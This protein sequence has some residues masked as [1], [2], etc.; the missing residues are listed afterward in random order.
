MK[1]LFFLCIV[2]Y[3]IL[4]AADNSDKRLVYWQM[5]ESS[6]RQEISGLNGSEIYPYVGDILSNCLKHSENL[7]KAIS[8][9]SASDINAEEFIDVYC[10]K[11][12]DAVILRKIGTGPSS[13]LVNDKIKTF[14]ISDI[15]SLSDELSGYHSDFYSAKLVD[16][17]ADE[18]LKKQL[19]G[20][21]YLLCLIDNYESLYSQFKNSAFIYIKHSADVSNGGR[22]TAPIIRTEIDRKVREF[23]IE[24]RLE[25]S[26]K[27]FDSAVL[28]KEISYLASKRLNLIKDA[29]VFLK[30]IND[31]DSLERGDYYIDKTAELEKAYFSALSEK[32]Y[33]ADTKNNSSVKA[34]GGITFSA[35]SDYIKFIA[36]IDRLRKE[37]T[38]LEKFKKSAEDLSAKYFS[39]ETP[40]DKRKA[41]DEYLKQSLNFT[42]WKEKAESVSVKDAERYLMREEPL[43][44]YISF[45]CEREKSAASL[46]SMSEG[47]KIYSADKQRIRKAEDSFRSYFSVDK[48][49]RENM[50]SSDYSKVSA[51]AAEFALFLKKMQ[52]IPVSDN[53]V[54]KSEKKECPYALSEI[55]ALS[56][57]IDQ[58]IKRYRELSYSADM[59]NEYSAV[60]AKYEDSAKS[61]ISSDELKDFYEKKTLLPYVKNYDQ[62]KID[63]ENRARDYIA[64]MLV[65]DNAR[66]KQVSDYYARMGL[67]S[68]KNYDAELKSIF[69]QTHVK[70]IGV[71]PITVKSI[72][73]TD[74]KVSAYIIKIIERKRWERGDAE[75]TSDEEYDLPEFGISV[76]IPSG[77]ERRDGD[78]FSIPFVN[79]SDGSEF[80]VSC[81]KKEEKTSMSAFDNWA[82][83]RRL[84]LVKSGGGKYQEKEFI[85]R[86]YENRNRRVVLAYCAD[87]N[88]KIIIISGE[89]KKEKY[90][91]FAPRIDSLFKSLKE[92]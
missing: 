39:S 48:T 80:V 68:R 60:F 17:I 36:E 87:F 8:A 58:E 28:T 66:I 23:D 19:L 24:A 78:E 1:K 5:R 51:S 30:L 73:Q 59:I 61:G 75:V 16:K 49:D 53:A 85:S 3:S 89:V 55:E 37:N 27:T 54:Q 74:K 18:K 40:V 81:F 33:S 79:A 64:K 14:L 4:P 92:K 52:T 29:S 46:D 47:S 7:I 84:R 34:E 31:A 44:K 35:D 62:N 6:I 9:G 41:A 90:Q 26:K 25:I 56:S 91:Y 32:N 12:F 50:S 38:V 22:F 77:W 82:N 67:C 83:I 45:I 15:N 69:N 86:V 88:E 20:E 21:Y 10:R 11:S 72:V 43:K 71:F 65:N 13:A 2:I 76:M 42:A 57:M 63:S 70:K